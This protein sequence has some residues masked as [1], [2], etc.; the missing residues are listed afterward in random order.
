MVFYASLTGQYWVSPGD[1][2]TLS[3]DIDDRFFVVEIPSSPWFHKSR[4]TLKQLRPTESDKALADV[5]VCPRECES[6]LQRAWLSNTR[7]AER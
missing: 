5:W 3:E 4:I 2:Y 6:R 7:F 1:L